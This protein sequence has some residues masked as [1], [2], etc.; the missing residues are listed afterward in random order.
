MEWF[1]ALVRPIVM[2]SG[3]AVVLV[4]VLQYPTAVFEF[5]AGAVLMILGYWFGER[6]HN[7]K[8]TGGNENASRF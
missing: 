7:K 6:A 2:L 1:S 3:W 5:F 4:L 8:T